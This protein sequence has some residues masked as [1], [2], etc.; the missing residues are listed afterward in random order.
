MRL[1]IEWEITDL[2]E[3]EGS[4]MGCSDKADPIAIRTGE[5]TLYVT[6]E[7]RTYKRCRYGAA[8]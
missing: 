5:C 7:F 4:T 1:Q 2:I 6:E 3:K 8:I